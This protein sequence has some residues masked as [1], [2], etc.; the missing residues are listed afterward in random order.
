[1]RKIQSAQMAVRTQYN[2]LDELLE[3]VPVGGTLTQWYNVNATP[4]YKPDRTVENLLLKVSLTVTDVDSHQRYTPTISNVTWYYITYTSGGKEQKNAC[5]MSTD[6]YT[7]SGNNLYVKKNVPPT[8]NGLVIHA[9]V[10]Y[11]DPRS[12]EA[13]TISKRV[14]LITMQDSS[15]RYDVFINAPK[16]VRFDPLTA[17]SASVSISAS[18]VFGEQAADMT[19]VAF[20]WYAKDS[21]VTADTKIDAVDS[22]VSDSTHKPVNVFPCYVS[23]QGTGTLVLNAMY[24]DELAVTC[25]LRLKSGTKALLP[26]TDTVTVAWQT[27]PLDAQVY[28]KNGAAVRGNSTDK[29]FGLLVN[30]KGAATMTDAQVREHFIVNWARRNGI[31]TSTASETYVSLGSGPEKTVPVSVLKST[32]NVADATVYDSKVIKAEVNLLGPAKVTVQDDAVVVD[33]SGYVVM[34]RD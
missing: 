30:V 16:V 3:I 27:A 9:D 10:T 4:Q 20:E 32:Y 13:V 6:S 21:S 19:A 28:S 5:A 33:D 25:R 22:T 2:A 15:A 34:M 26:C 29:T 12:S 24:C 23:G 17:A 14:T 31:G 11:Y 7:V 18:A 1:M 8:G